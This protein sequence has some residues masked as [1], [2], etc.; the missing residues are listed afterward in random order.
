M[1]TTI[2]LLSRPFCRLA[3]AAPALTCV[4]LRT[5]RL[6]DDPFEDADQCFCREWPPKLGGR[7]SDTLKHQC[8][9]IRLIHGLARAVFDFSDLHGAR[10]PNVQQSYELLVNDVDPVS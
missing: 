1:T 2:A 6:I 3:L 4:A 7:T 8:L 9:S 5:A 10:H